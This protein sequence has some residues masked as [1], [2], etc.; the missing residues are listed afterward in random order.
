MTF[1]SRLKT[2][3]LSKGLT[4][5]ELAKQLH[6][7]ATCVNRYERDIR[8]P[9]I[10]VISVLA[11]FFDVDCGYLLGAPSKTPAFDELDLALIQKFHTLDKRG[12]ATVL[13]ALEHEYI[14]ATK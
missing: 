5:A 6:L 1:G 13:N 10:G 11:D 7:S 12:Q 4:Q 8:E 3:R 2:L 14:I 9:G